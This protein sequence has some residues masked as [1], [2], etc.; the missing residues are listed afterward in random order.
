M[1]KN[2][3]PSPCFPKSRVLNGQKAAQTRLVFGRKTRMGQSGPI[4]QIR[5]ILPRILLYQPD[6]TVCIDRT[7][8]YLFR[9][10]RPLFEDSIDITCC[11]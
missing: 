5:P 10:S 11:Q 7:D 1:E 2:K 4:G 6:G 9:P 8:P 3:N